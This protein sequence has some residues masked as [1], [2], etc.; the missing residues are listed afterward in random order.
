[1]F[2]KEGKRSVGCLLEFFAELL[3]EL[4]LYGVWEILTLI[5]PKKYVSPRFEKNARKIVAVVTAI[6]IVS[7]FVGIILF[8]MEITLGKILMIISASLILL[9]V[10][11][12]IIQKIM[13]FIKDRENKRK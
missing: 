8:S 1:M 7:L 10:L 2:K 9:Q 6:L 12:G 11:L 3:F 5:I 13:V 4:I